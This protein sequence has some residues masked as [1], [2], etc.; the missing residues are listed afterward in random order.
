MSKGPWTAASRAKHPRQPAIDA[1]RRSA[2]KRLGY[3]PP[4]PESECPPRPADG[5]CQYCH[6]PAAPLLMDHNHV[7]G[8]FCAWACAS[9]NARVTDR[10][11]PLGETP[12]REPEAERERN[13]EW[14]K[15]NREYFREYLRRERGSKRRYTT[16]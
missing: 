3:A 1:T 6:K 13:R 8:A 7:T 5:R 15:A 10:M 9:C 2:A 11:G 4:P 14:S 16:R 12:W